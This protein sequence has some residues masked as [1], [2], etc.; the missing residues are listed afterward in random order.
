MSDD[1]LKQAAR[2]LREGTADADQPAAF[3]RARV[4]ASLHGSKRR[5]RWHVAVLVPIA[6]VLAGSTALA[7]SGKGITWRQVAVAI[8]LEKTT[9][10]TRP[11]A[12]KV[13]SRARLRTAPRTERAPEPVGLE[14]LIAEP[15]TLPSP[16]P[17]RPP[18]LQSRHEAAPATPQAAAKRAAESVPAFTRKARP[19]DPELEL[20]RSAHALHFSGADPRAAL[21][22]WDAYLERAPRGRFAIEARYNR[23]I[24]LARLGEA[25]AAQSAL[26]PFASGQ[27]GEYRKDSA[28]TLLEALG[29]E[30]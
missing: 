26:E 3:T 16:E 25:G 11:V 20:Y 29:A 15:A 28:R 8:G 14:A 13:F 1:I 21:A 12:P 27:Y 19:A 24:C 4:M 17:A 7:G 2:A 5:R 22:A 18:G 30:P 23:A 10:E 9:P 6:A